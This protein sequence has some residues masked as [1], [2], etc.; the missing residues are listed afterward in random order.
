VEIFVSG[1]LTAVLFVPIYNFF[2][3][4]SAE[5]AGQLTPASEHH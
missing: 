4:R 1:I 5:P 3:G 2:A